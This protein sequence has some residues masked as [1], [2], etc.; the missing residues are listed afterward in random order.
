MRREESDAS[1]ASGVHDA[2]RQA[3]P[4]EAKTESLP[5]AGLPRPHPFGQPLRAQRAKGVAICIPSGALIE[6]G[7][8]GWPERG[9]ILPTG[10]F[11]STARDGLATGPAQPAH[12]IQGTGVVSPWNS[13]GSGPIH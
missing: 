5:R 2:R 10:L 12:P 13:G 6:Q 1:Q 3:A 8:R 4:S 11:A 9:Q 7:A